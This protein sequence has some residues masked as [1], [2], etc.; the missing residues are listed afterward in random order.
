MAINVLIADQERTFADV[1]AARLDD[2][3]DIEVTDAVQI[4][5]LNAALPARWPAEV[6]LLD[7]DLPSNAANRVCEKVSGDE[8][9]RVIM[10]SFSSEPERIVEAFRSGASAWVR[11][12]ESLD[13]LLRVI[14]GV[15]RGESW[16]PPGETHNVLQ[17][18]MRV[19]ERRRANELLL[20]KLTARERAVLACLAEGAAHRDVV[21]K[22]LHLSVNTV[23]T[24]VRNLLTKLG[25]HSTLEAVA[26]T[27]EAVALAT[28]SP[29]WLHGEVLPADGDSAPS[30]YGARCRRRHPADDV[31][32]RRQLTGAAAITV[33]LNL[34]G[35]SRVGAPH[36]AK[37]SR[38]IEAPSILSPGLISRMGDIAA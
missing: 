5:A 7:S 22:Q 18:L 37:F 16:L 4:Q 35:T 17:L 29:G 31:G 23:R 15:A 27:R 30:R 6:M 20:A 12:D 33:A 11:K 2:E 9:T 34:A 21:A 38:R 24:H 3:D 32:Q 1:L 26:L 25:V 19:S 8:P 36:P 13:Y 28:D 10:L 14:R